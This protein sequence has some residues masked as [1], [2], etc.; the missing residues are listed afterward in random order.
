MANNSIIKRIE[1][2]EKAIITRPPELTKSLADRIEPALPKGPNYRLVHYPERPE[3]DAAFEAGLRE[4]NP[5]EAERLDLLLQ[6]II[7]EH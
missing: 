6:G 4:H 3:E 1:Q 5:A 7:P 2:L